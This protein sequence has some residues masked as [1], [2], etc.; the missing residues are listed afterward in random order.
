[1]S[2]WIPLYSGIAGQILRNNETVVIVTTAPA[3][4]YGAYTLT[5]TILEISDQGIVLADSQQHSSGLVTVVGTRR[6]F[7]PWR[8]IASVG[9]L[10]EWREQEETGGGA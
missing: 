9:E 2:E 5:G 6:T 3:G 10:Y 1:M 8:N 7:F 4:E